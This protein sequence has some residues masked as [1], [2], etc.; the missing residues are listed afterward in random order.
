MTL[1]LILASVFSYIVIKM[2]YKNAYVQGV[3][4]SVV[5]GVINYA[6]KTLVKFFVTEENHKYK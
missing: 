3:L 2:E 1:M 5:V 4:L 6:F